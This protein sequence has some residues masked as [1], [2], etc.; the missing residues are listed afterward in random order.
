MFV[1]SFYFFT[2]DLDPNDAPI[3]YNEDPNY[4][5]ALHA[6]LMEDNQIIFP[7]PSLITS[8]SHVKMTDRDW[9]LLRDTPLF[10]VQEIYHVVGDDPRLNIVQPFYHIFMEKFPGTYFYYYDV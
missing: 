2:V 9:D 7:I 10:I 1:K 4:D 6:Q 8:R 5:P 3:N